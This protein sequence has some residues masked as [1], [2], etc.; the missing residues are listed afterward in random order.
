MLR[1]T[2]LGTGTSLGA[3]VVTCPCAVCHSDDPRNQR[4]RAGLMLEWPLPSEHQHDTASVLIDTSTDFRQQALRAPVNR[5]D[6][7]MYTHQHVDHLL[8]LDELRIFNFVHLTRIPLYGNQATLAAIERIFDYAFDPEA[9]SVPRLTLHQLDEEL[10][11]LG[12]KV[13]PITVRHGSMDVLAFRID[14]FAYVTDCNCIP[15]DAADRLQKLDIL[16]IDALRRDPHPSHFNLEGALAEIER[17][18]PRVAYLT[19]LGHEFDHSNLESE[20]PSNVNV[21]YDGLVL[22]LPGKIA[23]S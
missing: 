7:V 10:D 5:V 12:K 18:R 14:D 23:K 22:E 16:V 9:L 8:G 17:L 6:A 13:L 20:L 1:V 15:A 2:F 19:H 21:A 11:L 3:P 4:L